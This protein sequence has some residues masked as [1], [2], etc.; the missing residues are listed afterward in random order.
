MV[1]ETALKVVGKCSRQLLSKVSIQTLE[2]RRDTD[3]SEG[4]FVRIMGDSQVKAMYYLQ[5]HSSSGCYKGSGVMGGVF[6]KIGVLADLEVTLVLLR[7]KDD[8]EAGA[9]NLRQ[10]EVFG[11]F[12]V[13]LQK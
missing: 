1:E 7:V 2:G 13:M 12:P 6:Y 10:A 11:A 5:R 9:T 8:L 3:S 4:E